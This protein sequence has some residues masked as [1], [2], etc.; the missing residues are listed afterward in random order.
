MTRK[1]KKDN[2]EQPSR[3]TEQAMEAIVLALNSGPRTGEEVVDECKSRGIDP[4]DDRAFGT[5]FRALHRAGRIIK[6]GYTQRRKGHGASGA[7]V[8]SLPAK[9]KKVTTDRHRNCEWCGTRFSF[10]RSTARFCSS[11][12]RVRAHQESAGFDHGL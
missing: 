4:C 11:T 9:N 12:C 5:A 3:F 7:I 1:R 2:R 10:L 8:W 6:A